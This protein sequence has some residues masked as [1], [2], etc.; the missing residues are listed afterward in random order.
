MVVAAAAAVPVR[1]G[2]PH[3]AVGVARER[4]AGR[5]RMIMMVAE[6]GA[7][8]WWGRDH[9]RPGRAAVAGG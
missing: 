9:T 7:V 4:E 2:W 1:E 3:P 8:G 6:R 5:A